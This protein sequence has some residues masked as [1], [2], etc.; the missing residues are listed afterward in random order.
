MA[1]EYNQMRSRKALGLVVAVAVCEIAGAVG[2]VFTASSVTTWY[3]TLAK[4]AFTPPDWVFG[5]V[6][7]T[8]Y[9]LMGIAAWLVW[10]SEAARS[11]VTRALAICALQL[12]LNV[13]WSV[14]FFGLRSPLWAFV[15]IVLL[16]FVIL[17]TTVWFFRV[18]KAAGVLMLPYLLWV[19]F[20]AALNF[21][22][23]RLNV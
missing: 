9:A 4:P 1:V 3:L 22:I 10:R 18:S 17:L 13:L 16:W 23:A 21:D 7:T 15:E 19:T 8:L 6:W 12:A 14:I 2:G 5:P 11:V 20:A